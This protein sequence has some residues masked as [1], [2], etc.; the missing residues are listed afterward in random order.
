[1]FMRKI[2]RYFLYFAAIILLG[3]VVGSNVHAATKIKPYKY[4]RIFYYRDSKLARQSL[5]THPSYIDVLAPQ[6]YA[7]NNDG[8]LVGSINASIISFAQKHK[9]K[10]MPLVTNDEFS[11][12]SYEAILDNMTTQDIAI[13]SLVS[14]ARK[15]NYWGWQIDFE[16]MDASYKDKYSDFIK[17][18]AAELHKNN[19]ILSV[20]VIA[21]V[22]DDP[23]DYPNDLWRKTIGVYDYSNLS[24][25]ADLIS[26]MSYDDPNSTGPVAEYPW[27]KKV[28]DYSV[29]LMP[30]SK[31]SLGIPFYYWQ[32]SNATGKR[33]GIGGKIGINNVIKKH[34][35]AYHYSTKQEAPYLTYWN[36]SKL[37]TI[38]YENARSIKKR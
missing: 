24:A 3:G 9:I 12:D 11:Q 35:V 14:E 33:I 30:A 36:H 29:K 25:S 4:T 26:I 37:Y 34:R 15:N 23:N 7:F 32:W 28:I 31:I 1:M 22:S 17:K 16:Q 21:K 27:L 5:F 6:S 10:V 13:S 38:W 20:A 2:T 18:A 8:K 19:L